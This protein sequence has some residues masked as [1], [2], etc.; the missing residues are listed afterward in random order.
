MPIKK[1]S[2]ST[3]VVYEKRII[4]RR[5]YFGRNYFSPR[6]GIL[7]RLYHHEHKQQVQAQE[8]VQAQAQ[9]ESKR[10]IVENCFVAI[11]YDLY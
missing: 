8:Q 2:S 3:N 10:N 4:C 11:E 5:T 6:Q 7:L 1:W 9:E